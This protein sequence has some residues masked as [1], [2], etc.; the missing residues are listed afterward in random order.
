[1]GFG[2]M[3]D[4]VLGLRLLLLVLV[5]S[6]GGF[7]FRRG[8]ERGGWLQCCDSGY[9]RKRKK[10]EEMEKE[11]RTEE[12]GTENGNEKG[13]KEGAREREGGWERGAVEETAVW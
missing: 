12:K 3:A 13:K 8:A 2:C 7:L 5:V 1:M 6:A 9:N 10:G 4:L 11:K